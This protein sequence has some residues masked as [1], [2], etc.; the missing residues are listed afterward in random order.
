MKRVVLNICHAALAGF[1]AS[2]PKEFDLG[3]ATIYNARNKIKVFTLPS[4]QKVNVKRYCQ[5]LFFNRL[6][7]TFIRT[8]KA[9]RAYEYALKLITLGVPT[10]SPIAYILESGCGLL[11]QSYLI[12]EQSSLSRMFYEFGKGGIAGREFILDA[13]AQFTAQLHDKG[14]YHKDYSPGNILFDVI[15]GIPQFTLVDI[16]RMEFGPVD[17]DNG[18]RNFARLWGNTEMFELLAVS[19]AK[20]RG[21]DENICR[22][23]LLGYRYKFWKNHKDKVLFDYE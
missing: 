2:I 19:Y 7:Y 16:N 6:V 9:V 21:F 3:G 22:H 1:V 23:L 8:P 12:T 4:G 20:A 18:C 5:P 15:N 10:P 14:V 13:F 17:M 11:T